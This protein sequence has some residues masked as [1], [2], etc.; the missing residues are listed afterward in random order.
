VFLRGVLFQPSV[1][2]GTRLQFCVF[3]SPSNDLPGHFNTCGMN[4]HVPLFSLDPNADGVS[5]A[6]VFHRVSVNLNQ[7][8]RNAGHSVYWAVEEA[9]E[10]AAVVVAACDAAAGSMRTV[11]VEVAV[12]PDWSVAPR[13]L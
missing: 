4:G 7:K 3:P 2:H 13:S 6:F 10:V 5:Y 8:L 1:Y 12:R 9:V 11:R